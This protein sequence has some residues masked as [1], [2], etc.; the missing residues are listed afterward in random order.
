MKR[1]VWLL[2][3]VLAPVLIQVQPVVL[4]APTHQACCCG[5][6]ECSGACGMPGCLPPPASSST[7]PVS[8]QPAKLATV[9]LRRVGQPVV[10]ECERFFAAFVKSTTAPVAMRSPARIAA[11]ASV[12]L[13]MAHCSLLV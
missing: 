3:A 11:P 13:F 4:S 1:L 6:G 7:L 5:C 12:P 2:L 8:A 9:A 10:R